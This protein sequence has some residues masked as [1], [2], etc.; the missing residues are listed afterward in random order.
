MRLWLELVLVAVVAV[1]SAWLIEITNIARIPWYR[2]WAFAAALLG[3][4]V[5]L[6]AAGRAWTTWRGRTTARQPG[7]TKPR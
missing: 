4:L 1:A 7:K 6:W 3:L 5:C 2:R